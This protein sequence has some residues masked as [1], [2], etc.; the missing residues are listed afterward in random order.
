[1]IIRQTNETA[2]ASIALEGLGGETPAVLARKYQDL[3][4]A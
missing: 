3:M 1:M 2:Y 4:D